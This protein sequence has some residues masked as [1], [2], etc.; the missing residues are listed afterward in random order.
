MSNGKGSSP[1]EGSHRRPFPEARGIVYGGFFDNRT[2]QER[3]EDNWELVFGSKCRDCANCEHP[4]ATLEYHDGPNG[5]CT[6]GAHSWSCDCKKFVAK[7]DP[8]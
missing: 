7:K 1:R 2:P 5:E 8:N 3:Y 6:Q 4:C